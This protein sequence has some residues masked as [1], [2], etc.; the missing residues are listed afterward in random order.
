MYPILFSIK[1]VNF[2][3]Y[4]LMVAL[5]FLATASLMLYLAK[6]QKLYSLVLF[7]QLILLFFAGL[8]GARLLYFIL[9]YNQFSHWYEIFYFW[10]GGMVSFGGFAGVLLLAAYFFR[11][12]LLSW[13][14]IIAVSF[15]L[16]LFF[17][18]MG[19]FLAGDHPQVVSDSFLAIQGGF[20]SILLESL[21]GLLGLGIFYHLY[22]QLK[23]R[24]GL[25]F[26]MVMIYY[27]LLRMILDQ[28]RIDPMIWGLRTGQLTGI[29]LVIVGI[30]A[31]II[32]R[33]KDVGKNN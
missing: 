5:S 28:F 6:K 17:W 31:I 26:F 27:G 33:R 1:G 2:Y 23:S 3:S 21:F 11:K 16:G 30:I 8:I 24:P 18:R 19:C 4:G 32:L 10:Q 15:L 9:Y 14:D 7:D 12:N 20:P 29:A 25:I 13:F 22:Q